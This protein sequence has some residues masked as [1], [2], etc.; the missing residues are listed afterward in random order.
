MG[1]GEGS[2]LRYMRSETWRDILV[3]FL[4]YFILFYSVIRYLPRSLQ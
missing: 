3:Y 1:Q 4:L 2:F